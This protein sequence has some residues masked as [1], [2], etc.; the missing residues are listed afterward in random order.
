MASIAVVELAAL[1]QCSLFDLSALDRGGTDVADRDAISGDARSDLDAAGESGDEALGLE[2]AGDGGSDDEV[3]L[4]AAAD[5]RGDEPGDDAVA[6]DVVW[7]VGNPDVFVEAGIDLGLVALYPFDET[8]GTTSAD[9]S[10]NGHAASLQGATFGPGLKNNAATMNGIGQ[11]VTLPNAIVNGLTSFSIST[12]VN[13]NAAPTHCHIFDFGSSPTTYMF[14]TPHSGN[15][16]LQ[17]A[18]TT[19]GPTGEE[20]INTLMLATGSWQHVAVTLG[21]RTGI[22]Y[23]NGVRVAQNAT[24]VLT[25]TSLGA[26]T[27]NWLGRSQFTMDPYLNARIDQ[28]RIYDRALSAAEVQQ[29]FQ[30]QL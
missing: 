2:A 3:V 4:D 5:S 29:L 9:T 10:G 13:L 18:I 28:F 23:V 15:R 19:G 17:F 26:T 24:M 25:P 8:S 1:C 27:N 12:W 30:R 22:L 14:L 7:D 11:Y 6:T 21:G 20:T 16:T